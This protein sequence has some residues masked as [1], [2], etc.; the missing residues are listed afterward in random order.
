MI[1]RCDPEIATW[2][3][4]GDNFVVKNV[5]T[6]ASV[7]N[8]VVAGVL[9]WLCCSPLI[10]IPRRFVHCSMSCPFISN[11]PILVALP[12]RYV[13]ES[14]S[15]S[16]DKGL[17]LDLY[18]TIFYFVGLQLNF[19]GF[20]KLRS[21]PILTNDVDPR[22]ACYVRFYHDKFQKDRPE[23][24]HQIKRAT[25]SE[26]QSKDEVES[27]KSEVTKLKESIS[28]LNSRVH[29]LSTDY[30]KLAAL[31]T[32]ILTRQQQ[33]LCVQQE[34]LPQQGSPLNAPDLMHSLSQV[35]ALSLQNQLR[36]LI[37]EKKSEG[38]VAGVKRG[39][40]EDHEH[41]SS[42]RQKTT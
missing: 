12:D 35:A 15:P 1:D 28:Q 20:R 25:K 6:F 38:V 32:E 11:I 2:S 40:P 30:D 26:Q 14:I 36:P 7:R 22:T 4:T 33:H 27:L 19:Y 8:W 10:I 29:T 42:N 24:L 13:R 16:Q 41:I 34:Q 37:S 39:V 21:D 18:L 17:H 31:I 9:F 5:E 3:K 23:L